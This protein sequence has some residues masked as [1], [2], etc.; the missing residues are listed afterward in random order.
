MTVRANGASGKPVGVE[1]LSDASSQAR[2]CVEG[3]ERIERTEAG[4]ICG[5]TLA[6]AFLLEIT[7]SASVRWPIG[8]VPG[9][10][11]I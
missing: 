5:G 11:L 10:S 8:G 9:A 3:A 2:P 1:R 4:F 7:D 6:S